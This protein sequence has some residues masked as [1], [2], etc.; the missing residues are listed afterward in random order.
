MGKL[1][2]LL[3]R[4]YDTTNSNLACNQN[5]S[6]G[7]SV[8]DSVPNPYCPPPGTTTPPSTAAA[9]S[10]SRGRSSSNGWQPSM[11]TTT[12]GDLSNNSSG[13]CTP[14]M[15]TQQGRG[16]DDGATG[17]DAL[18]VPMYVVQR[19]WYAGPRV[20]PPIDYRRLLPSRAQAEQVAY[21]SAHLYATAAGNNSGGSP[22]AVRTLQLPH[23]MGLGFVAA[24]QLFWVRC[25]KAVASCGQIRYGEAHCIV[26]NNLLDGNVRR[27]ASNAAAAAEPCRI[28]VG[29]HSSHAALRLIHSG[30]VPEGSAVQWIPVGMPPT[31]EQLGAEWPDSHAFQQAN[32]AA[33]QDDSA[34]S[35]RSSSTNENA[36][37][38][39]HWY[40]S[41][42]P[43]S[44]GASAWNSTTSAAAA[45]GGGLDVMMAMK[46]DGAPP[47]SKRACR[48]MST[49]NA[50]FFNGLSAMT[51]MGVATPSAA[52]A[53]TTASHDGLM[54]MEH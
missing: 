8:T 16:S 12:E 33:M 19:C 39:Q 14:P 23:D 3:N 40:Y 20:Q 42:T 18:V 37:G 1:Q 36:T 45:A 50:L 15:M 22:V 26:R 54:M 2:F 32:G 10:S 34:S 5:P 38:D 43:S 9:S 13:S 46:E 6:W 48:P 27:C 44:N 49:Q 24:G 35:K 4:T 52:A 31:P 51:A 29:P 17:A 25:L 30:S 11:D 21:G 47:P 53:T 28:F 7:A 41:A